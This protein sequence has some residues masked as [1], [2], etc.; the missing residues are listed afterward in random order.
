MQFGRLNYTQ[1]MIPDLLDDFEAMQFFLRHGDQTGHDDSV[2]F[3]SPPGW[4]SSSLVPTLMLTSASKGETVACLT[5]PTVAL[6]NSRYMSKLR[7][8]GYGTGV[9]D[10]PNGVSDIQL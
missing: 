10:L 4:T 2:R 9:D 3:W 5:G 1:A 8:V 7:K 6:L